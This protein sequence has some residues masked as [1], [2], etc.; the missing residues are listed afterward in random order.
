M[1]RHQVGGI[2]C[3]TDLL[4][5]KLLVLLSLLQ[6]LILCL[7]VF[8]GAAPTAESQSSCC[9]PDSYVSLVSP[10]ASLA[11]RTMLWYSDSALLSDTSFSVD[12]QVA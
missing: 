5:P 11:Q 2:D 8:D 3:A 4:D 12:D 6:P 7:H 10:M 1:L 9:C